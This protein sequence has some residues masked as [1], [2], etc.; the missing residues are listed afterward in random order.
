[1]NQPVA[2][3]ASQ[4]RNWERH[5]QDKKFVRLLTNRFVFNGGADQGGTKMRLLILA[6]CLAAGLAAQT[7]STIKGRVYDVTGGILDVAKLTARQVDTGFE[8]A[9]AALSDG[10]YVLTEL[11]AGRYELRAEQAGFR[12]L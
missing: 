1:R 8:R 7:T 4:K 2:R 3:S 10:S 11:P 12:P 5:V 9:A 6:V